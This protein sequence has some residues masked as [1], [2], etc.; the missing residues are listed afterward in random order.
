MRAKHVL[1]Y[2]LILITM[3]INN[4]PY[5]TLKVEPYTMHSR[6]FS[7]M[8]WGVKEYFNQNDRLKIK[9]RRSSLASILIVLLLS[10]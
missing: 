5:N 10:K 4:K 6:V 7:D 1:S 8:S 3:E 2:H 9:K